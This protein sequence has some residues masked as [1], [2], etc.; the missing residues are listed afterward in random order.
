ML[1]PIPSANTSLVGHAGRRFKLTWTYPFQ[2]RQ[3]VLASATR[4]AIS[5]C[6][7]NVTAEG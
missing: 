2:L 1:V 4:A 6:V 3:A 7:E 5:K